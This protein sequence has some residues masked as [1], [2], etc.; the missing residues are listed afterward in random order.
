MSKDFVCS[1]ERIDICAG[2][3][4]ADLDS[5]ISIE[6]MIFRSIFGAMISVS[7]TSVLYDRYGITRISLKDW[8]DL[9]VGLCRVCCDKGDNFLEDVFE[10]VLRTS[11]YAESDKEVADFIQ[12]PS[13]LRAI[14]GEYFRLYKWSNR[15]DEKFSRVFIMGV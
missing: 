10:R 3:E 4:K 15:L 7:N 6:D 9:I 12:S 14:I 1:G 11:V 13:A 2:N 8:T 5:L